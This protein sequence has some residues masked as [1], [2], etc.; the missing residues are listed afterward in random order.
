M[1]ASNDQTTRFWS[2]ERPGEATSVEKPSDVVDLSGQDDDDDIFV[3]GFGATQSNFIGSGFGI[4]FGSSS[5]GGYNRNRGAMEEDDSQYRQSLG[6]G[7]VGVENGYPNRSGGL[8]QSDSVDDFIPGFS[9]SSEAASR[10]PQQQDMY[11]GS[12]LDEFGRD[13]PHGTNGREP[14]GRDDRDGRERDGDW[15]RGGGANGHS[16]GGRWGPRRG[17]H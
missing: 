8:G 10:P 17:R 9:A 3:P 5:S 16:R 4:G 6:M 12:M 13:V 15:G 14:R 1:T 2:R 11:G 7:G